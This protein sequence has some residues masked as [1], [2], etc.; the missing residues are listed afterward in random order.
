M[1]LLGDSQFDGC[2]FVISPLK[3][4]HLPPEP[5]AEG[6]WLNSKDS[7]SCKNSSC[8]IIL[9]LCAVVCL[10]RNLEILLCIIVKIPAVRKTPHM[11]EKIVKRPRPRSPA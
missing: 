1:S 7:N 6:K 4:Q 3:L 2:M 8:L 5:K 11:R 10:N 9:V